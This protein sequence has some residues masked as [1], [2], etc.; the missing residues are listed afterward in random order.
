M[1]V[2][3]PELRCPPASHG[4]S[5]LERFFVAIPITGTASDRILA[6]QPPP[7]DGVRLTSR[8]DLHLTLHFLGELP[9]PAERLATDA[10][11]KLRLAPFP[12]TLQGVGSFATTDGAQVLWVGGAPTAELTALHSAIAG[13]LAEA[14]AYKP[15]A[16]PYRPHITVA[17]LG[18]LD[19]VALDRFLKENAAIDFPPFV[20]TEFA[21][22]ASTFSGD[23][24]RYE[25]RALYRL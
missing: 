1:P 23:G 19:A 25:V 13:S 8:A 2:P 24:P 21:L 14:I 9:P 15:E 22:Y 10:L 5:T 7:A 3:R 4:K 11:K 17:R 16:R 6:L 20:V 12:L 18:P